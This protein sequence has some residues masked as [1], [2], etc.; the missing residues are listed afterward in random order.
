MHKNQS[1]DKIS[2]E[3]KV[4]SQNGLSDVNSLIIHPCIHLKLISI[5]TTARIFSATTFDCTL[6][7]FGRQ[8]QLGCC[9]MD[10]I[11][12]FCIYYFEKYQINCGLVYIIY[13]HSENRSHKNSA[14]FI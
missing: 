11:Y 9:S 2:Y 12:S 1:L 14:D 13:R 7:H 6:S 8:Y 4:D 5:N 3:I 10:L